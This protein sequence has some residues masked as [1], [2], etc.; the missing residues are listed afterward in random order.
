[1]VWQI[2]EHI[3]K[4]RHQMTVKL[5]Q[6]HYLILDSSFLFEIRVNLVDSV[7]CSFKLRDFK[8]F[9]VANI[10]LRELT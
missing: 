1:M 4:L 8:L 7:F 2:L 6:I 10:L 9:E 3:L 5:I